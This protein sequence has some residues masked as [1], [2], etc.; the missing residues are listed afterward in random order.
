M[1]GKISVGSSISNKNTL[2]YEGLKRG[3]LFWKKD[4]TQK[5]NLTKSIF[6][7]KLK[8]KKDG[9]FKR[10]IKKIGAK[11]SSNGKSIKNNIK[12]KLAKLKS[13]ISN[14]M[15]GKTAKILK[16]TIKFIGKT[17]AKVAKSAYNTTKFVAKTVVKGVKA[18]VKAS[19][20]VGKALFNAPKV[21]KALVVNPASFVTKLGFKALKFI[22]KKLWKGIKKLAIKMGKVLGNVFRI[23]KGF[24][25][26]IS[27]YVGKIGRGIK[28]KAYRF[29]I[30]PIASIL[31]TVFGFTMSVVLSPVQFMKSLLPTIMDRFF[32]LINNVK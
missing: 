19:H 28:D 27:T 3:L 23:G 5:N 22:G 6:G 18:F 1:I 30:K 14:S 21:I 24:V 25:N 13:R 11:I 9:F 31:V 10:N 29:L 26:K 15:I 7:V 16:N 8:A 20:F 17:T 32:D 2:K 4:T 12:K